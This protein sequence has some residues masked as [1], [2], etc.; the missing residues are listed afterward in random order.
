MKKRILAI[1]I[2]AV[3][4]LG[5][6][7]V[8]LAD[9]VSTEETKDIVVLYTNDTHCGVTDGM[10]F[11]GVARVKAAL[12]AAGYPVVLVDN[13]DAVQGD[14]IGTLSKGEAIIELMNTAGYEFA[15]IGNHDFD[16]GMEQFQ[17]NVGLAKFQYLC[18]NFLNA[19]GKPLFDS[20]AIKEIAGKKIGFIGIA[21]PQTFKTSTPTYFQD[22][23]HKYIYSF[24]EGNDGQDLYDA[25]QKAADD[26]RAAGAEYVIALAHLGNE[27]EAHPWT[28]SDVITHTTGIDVVLDGHSH[29]VMMG[30]KVDNANGEKVLLTQTGTKLANLGM[31]TI[32]KDGTLKTQLIGDSALALCNMTGLLTE[33]NGMEEAVTAALAENDALVNEVVAHTDVDLI[34]NDPI[35]VDKD[36]K[37]IRIVRSQETNLGDLCAD[38]YRAMGESD[39]AFVN[40]GGIRTSI[41]VGDITFGQIIQVHPFG[42]TMCVVE[43][44]GAEILDA[45]EFSNA[46]LPG[47]FGGFLQVS[48]LKFKIDMNVQPSIEKDEKGMFVAVTGDRRVK[49]VQVLQADGTYAPIDPEK[50]YTVSCHNYLLKNGGDGYTMFQDNVILR[51]EVM[52][53]NQVL[54]N[55]IVDVLQGTVGAGYSDPYGEG[56]ITFQ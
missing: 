55:Y 48:G 39:V 28:S 10:G 8:A 11:A 7:P 1:L 35:A 46:S 33:S 49:D 45:L 21:T 50:T 42:N 38:A 43:A 29:T 31:L 37:P 17:K 27:Y 19:E 36:G 22:E 24:C 47:E 3:M 44:T 32:G 26:A 40:G 41:P 25:V 54:I 23:N 34:I 52:I 4:L 13:G 9:D 51:D 20:F 18:C 5:L 6:V 14:V 12:E 15:A 2:A 56:R 16:Y 53:D 30:D